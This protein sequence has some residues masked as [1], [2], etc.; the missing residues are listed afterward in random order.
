MDNAN[1]QIELLT[2]IQKNLRRGDITK[3]AKNSGFSKDWVSKV[4]SLNN[5]GNYN[6][7]II[8]EAVKIIEPRIKNT[9][10]LIKKLTPCPA[11]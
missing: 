5:N 2:L 1:S 4:L 6:D 3:I 8:A 11:A 7:A 10:K 9:E